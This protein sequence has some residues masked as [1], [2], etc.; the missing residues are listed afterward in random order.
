MPTD[1]L[2]V[3][4]EGA[5]MSVAGKRSRNKVA[6]VKG[7]DNPKGGACNGEPDLVRIAL[8]SASFPAAQL[9]IAWPLPVFPAATAC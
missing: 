6:I 2:L 7:Q 9:S 3:Q 1:L 4:I 5:P 8:I